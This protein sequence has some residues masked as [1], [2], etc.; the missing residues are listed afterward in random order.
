VVVNQVLREYLQQGYLSATKIVRS[1]Q[2]LAKPCYVPPDPTTKSPITIPPT[3]PQ[4]QNLVKTGASQSNFQIKRRHLPLLIAGGGASVLLAVGV[5]MTSRPPQPSPIVA[6]N[7]VTETADN[8][9]KTEE[10]NNCIVVVRSSNLRSLS[11]HRKTGKVVKAG[12]KVTVTGRQQGGWLEISSPESGWIW[13]S[14]TRNV[15]SGK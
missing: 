7:Q 10:K 1:L 5:I 13:K 2:E 6:K 9:N 8:K 12:T 3:I 4:T 15:C 11:G 14:R